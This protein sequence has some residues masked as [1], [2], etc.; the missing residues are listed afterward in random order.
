MLPRS[1]ITGVAGYSPPLLADHRFLYRG[2]LALVALAVFVAGGV[3]G[4]LALVR[5][6]VGDD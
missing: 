3:V 5:L 6:G 4:G 2:P 1:G